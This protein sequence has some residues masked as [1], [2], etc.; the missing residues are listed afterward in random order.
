MSDDQYGMGKCPDIEDGGLA[1]PVSM[2]CEAEN[3]PGMSLRDWFA[4][5]ALSGFVANPESRRWTPPEV[6]TDAYAFADAMLFERN[7]EEQQ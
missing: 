7:L 2:N 1:F 5:Q 6:A 3:Y 4:G